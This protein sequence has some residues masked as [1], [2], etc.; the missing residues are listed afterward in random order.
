MELDWAVPAAAKRESA[1]DN[2]GIFEKPSIEG[3]QGF[4]S[5][6]Q[7]FPKVVAF[8]TRGGGNGFKEG[9]SVF[10]HI[11]LHGLCAGERYRLV[12]AHDWRYAA[13][14]FSGSAAPAVPAASP[15]PP[16]PHTARAASV[17]SAAALPGAAAASPLPLWR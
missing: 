7:S 13:P 15:P 1:K 14:S 11:Y 5:L 16:R 6:S 3:K 4:M 9:R 17:A 8:D 12:V 2:A 10:L